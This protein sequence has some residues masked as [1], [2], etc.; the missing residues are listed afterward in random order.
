M[1]QSSSLAPDLL[2]RRRIHIAKGCFTFRQLR[3]NN[4]LGRWEW[5]C[6]Y[7]RQLRPAF[8]RLA[9]CLNKLAVIMTPLITLAIIRI[10]FSDI[11]IPC[12]HIRST[13]LIMYSIGLACVTKS[14]VVP[15]KVC[16][17]Q[18]FSSTRQMLPDPCSWLAHGR[19]CACL[20]EVLRVWRTPGTRE[21]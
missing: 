18:Q 20:R 13:K 19:G 6:N 1:L 7:V 8:L 4:V 10:I 15:F 14:I 5:I 21:L 16:F 17:Q 2:R 3:L 12:W 9:G 11:C